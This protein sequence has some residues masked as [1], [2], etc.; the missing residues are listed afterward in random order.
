ML[1]STIEIGARVR[2]AAGYVPGFVV[3]GMQRLAARTRHAAN[4]AWLRNPRSSRRFLSDRPALAVTQQR[5]VDLLAA[6]GIASID[7]GEL[8]VDGTAY[9]ALASEI[10]AFARSERVAQGIAAFRDSVGRKPLQGDDYMIKLNPEGPSV[11]L[12]HP[13]LTV[14]LSPA[15][16]DVVNAYLGLWSKLI[17]A[18]GWHTV[19]VDAGKR[20]GS[21]DWHRDPEDGRMIKVYLY[22]NDV[23][24][25]CGPMEYVVGSAADGAFGRLW[26]WRPLATQAYR[27]PGTEAVEQAIGGAE[28]IVCTGA[29]GTV[30]FCDTSGLHRGGVPRGGARVLATWTFVTPAAISVTCRRRFTVVSAAGALRPA[31]AYALSDAF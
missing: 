24:P 19:P 2:R 31:A 4:A 25:D 15:I 26:R 10:D 11:P 9:A 20:I 21:Q 23:T 29:R 5:V 14:G 22:F 7:H 1:E 28:R 12:S 18:D 16:L 17:Y 6:R 3:G 8:G 13:L 30:T 27:Y